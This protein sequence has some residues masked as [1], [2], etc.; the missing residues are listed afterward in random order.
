M[1]AF[2]EEWVNSKNY[3][4]EGRRLCNN[5]IASIIFGVNSLLPGGL[6]IVLRHISV[7]V[8]CAC[9]ASWY[10]LIEIFSKE[11]W[12]SNAHFMKIMIKW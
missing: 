4:G 9:Q 3:K 7:V 2:E 6:L 5:S 11:L 1:E 12:I 8:R 10:Y